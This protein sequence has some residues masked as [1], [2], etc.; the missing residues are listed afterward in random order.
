MLDHAQALTGS[1]Q[2]QE[3]RPQVPENCKSFPIGSGNPG[4]RHK[5]NTEHEALPGSCKG[6]TLVVLVANNLKDQANLTSC[7]VA[8]GLLPSLV[9][10]PSHLRL[11][12]RDS[13][14]EVGFLTSLKPRLGCHRPLL[15]QSETPLAT[16]AGMVT[17]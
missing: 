11:C 12:A 4:S 2:P 5:T 9:C 6:A 16:Y 10:S 15:D 1:F 13:L 8:Q 14:T 17:W 7:S 3:A